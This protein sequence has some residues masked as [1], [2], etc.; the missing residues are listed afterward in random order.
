MKVVHSKYVNPQKRYKVKCVL[1]MHGKNISTNQ[2]YK[3]EKEYRK[4][5][6]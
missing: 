2:L 4:D 3:M 6:K 5:S 1:Y